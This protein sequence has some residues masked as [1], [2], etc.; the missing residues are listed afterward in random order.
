[1]IY[2]LLDKYPMEIRDADIGYTPNASNFERGYFWFLQNKMA[3]VRREAA[4]FEAIFDELPK[5]GGTAVEFFGGIG[6]C[7]TLIH[8]ILKPRT[9]IIYDIDPFCVSHLKHM[10]RK[11]RGVQINQGNVFAT[12]VAKFS[13]AKFFSFDFNQFT[14]LHWRDNTSILQTLDAVIKTAQPSYIQ[15]TDSAVN[16][17]HLNLGLYSSISGMDVSDITS[18]V[19]AF[20]KLALNSWNYSVTLAY[21]HFGATYLLLEPGDHELCKIDK[22]FV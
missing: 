9:H 4:C 22:V 5:L 21:Y 12:P 14:I 1:M 2:N 18:Y 15:L 11:W 19:R 16:K 7:S 6:M 8:E 17:L 13:H 3:D 10:T 20:S